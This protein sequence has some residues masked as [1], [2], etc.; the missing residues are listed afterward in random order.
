MF[1]ESSALVQLW[2]S[3]VNQGKYTKEDIPAISNLKEV[4]LSLLGE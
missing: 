1:N 3:A 4:V 2:V